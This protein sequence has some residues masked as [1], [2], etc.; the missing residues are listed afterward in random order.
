MLHQRIAVVSSSRETLD[1]VEEYLRRAG[2]RPSA[3]SVLEDAAGAAREA[4]ALVLFA[5]DF[6]TPDTLRAI[7][8]LAV[9]RLVVV[10]QEVESFRA[11]CDRLSPGR[12][13]VLRRPA[14]GWMLLEALRSSTREDSSGHV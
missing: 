13:V 2:A 12:L 14:W 11:R 6:P 5:D 9:E 4:D 3:V 7:D 8:H 1:G 10:T